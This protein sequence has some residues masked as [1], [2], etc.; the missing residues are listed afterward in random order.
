MEVYWIRLVSIEGQRVREDQFEVGSELLRQR[1]EGVF[2]ASG[3]TRAT[4]F[5]G[6][7]FKDKR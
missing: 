5:A 2:P 1:F 4:G 6:R 3:D 7:V